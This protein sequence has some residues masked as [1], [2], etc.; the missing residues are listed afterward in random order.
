[1]YIKKY[2]GDDIYDK[3]KINI[4]NKEAL[5]KKEILELTFHTIMQNSVGKGLRSLE[6]IELEEKIIRKI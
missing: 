4:E 3:I 2:N 5:S 6:S 1:M